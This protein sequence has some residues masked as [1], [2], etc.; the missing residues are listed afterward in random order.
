M[1]QPGFQSQG[2]KDS[3]DGTYYFIQGLFHKNNICTYLQCC[4]WSSVYPELASIMS[5]SL[6]AQYI[7]FHTNQKEGEGESFVPLSDG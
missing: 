3:N 5:H 1:W 2:L 4:P 6:L 7:S